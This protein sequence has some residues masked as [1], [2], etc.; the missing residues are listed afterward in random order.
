MLEVCTY[1]VLTIIVDLCMNRQ[2]R[3]VCGGVNLDHIDEP[4]DVWKATVS[5]YQV[6]LHEVYY[7]SYVSHHYR[8]YIS[9]QSVVSNTLAVQTRLLS[10][11]SLDA[12]SIE[13]CCLRR[14]QEQCSCTKL[15]CFALG[16]RKNAAC[17]CCRC[18]YYCCCYYCYY[19]Y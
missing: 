8:F 10:C 19:C 14:K 17:N 4:L 2:G 7:C 5:T 11:H 6:L 12:A 3:L 9:H 13:I 18:C 1:A 15:L 16:H